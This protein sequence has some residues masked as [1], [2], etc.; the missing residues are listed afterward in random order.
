[1]N[2]IFPLIER[3][4]LEWSNDH[5]NSGVN[6]SLW[7]Y[8]WLA[9]GTCTKTLNTLN[10]E[11]RYF[12]QALDWHQ[13]YPLFVYL[14]NYGFNPGFNYDI[15]EVFEAIK[16]GLGGIRPALDC[17]TYENFDYPVLSTI[18]LCFDKKLKLI[19]CQPSV[20]DS[21]IL[22]N[23]PKEGMVYYPREEKNFR[24]VKAFGK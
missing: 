21:G 17:K 9:H 24:I 1:M 5:A 16:T 2:S 20:Y 6:N 12:E 13:K 11:Y 23:C 15:W 14:H 3:L 4:T 7:K 22:G 19:N 10:S 8:E 18:G